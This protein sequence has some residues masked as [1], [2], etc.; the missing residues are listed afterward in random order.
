MKHDE[1]AG[2]AI[3]MVADQRYDAGAECRAR[4][5]GIA[6]EDDAARGMPRGIDTLP[7]VLVLGK[8]KTILP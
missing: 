4:G 6:D 8:Q 5:G 2:Q 7:E 3:A 1:A